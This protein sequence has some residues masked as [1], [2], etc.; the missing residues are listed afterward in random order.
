[1]DRER[2]W[3]IELSLGK[4]M[5]IAHIL[6]GLKNRRTQKPESTKDEST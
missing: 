2:G 1:M 5:E 4:I 3:G 6:P